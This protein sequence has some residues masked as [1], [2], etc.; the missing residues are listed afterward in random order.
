MFRE[1]ALSRLMK[2]CSY[3][4][5]SHA[6]VRNK[7]LKLKVYGDALESIISELITEGFLNEER[8]A[9]SYVRGKFKN[10]G[11]GRNKI[12]MGLKF[13]KVSA[14]SIQKGM[15]EIKEVEYRSVLKS[16]LRKKLAHLPIADKYKIFKKLT[17]YALQRGFEYE[18]VKDVLNEIIEEPQN[19]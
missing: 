18:L 3:Q 15:E 17:Q 4:E 7:L 10:N 16:V 5:R 2:Y 9:R 13:K 8:Y 14:Y 12:L 1:A 19:D 6:E 11:W